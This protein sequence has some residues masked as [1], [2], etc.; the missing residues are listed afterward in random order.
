[1]G[2]ETVRELE[3]WDRAIDELI[4]QYLSQE[5]R[6]PK[7]FSDFGPSDLVTR[8]QEFIDYSQI[9]K[10]LSANTISGYHLTL[11]RYLDFLAELEVNSAEEVTKDSLSAFAKRLQDGEGY[12]LS[13]RSTAGAFTAVR[14]FHRFMVMEGYTETDPTGI[15][16]SPRITMRIPRALNYE[17]VDKLLNVPGNDKKGMRDRLII[18]MLYASG[19]R[20]SELVGLNLGDFDISERL[21]TCRGKGGK[22]RIVPFGRPARESLETYLKEFRPRLACRWSGNAL[23]LNMYGGRLT[24]NGGWKIIKGHARSAGIENLVTP[25]VLRHTFATHLLEGGA[26][27]VVIQELLGHAS[28]STTQI[29][30][31]VTREHL[32]EVYRRTHPRA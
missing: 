3:E 20:I 32:M 17:Q 15:L 29:Y 31:E 12:N 28:I 27:L 14:M 5:F 25:H 16:K 7:D 1:L 6:V 26:N 22:W 21:V 8:A 24:R 4:D 19:M 13:P 2:L 11:I 30:T 18:E 9:E 23:I 10:G